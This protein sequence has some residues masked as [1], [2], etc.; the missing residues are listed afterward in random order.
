MARVRSSLETLVVSPRSPSGSQSP[1]AN[2]KK[3]LTAALRGKPPF[4]DP[5]HNL[6]FLSAKSNH[7]DA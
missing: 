3:L 7:A 2:A 5:W 4:W 1:L 6:F